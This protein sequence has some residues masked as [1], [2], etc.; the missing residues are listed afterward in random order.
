MS[1]SPK[2]PSEQQ[3]LNTQP[4]H[5]DMAWFYSFSACMVPFTSFYIA[6]TQG[7]STRA[8]EA[9][10]RSPIGVYG[11]LALPFVTL[12]MEKSIYDTVQSWQGL[13]PTVRPKDRGGFP[14][15]GAELL[16]SFSLIPVQKIERPSN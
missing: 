3:P 10:V 2:E 8:V 16:P 15:G 12:A 5:N 7:L 9:V 4:P 11:L 14:S 13:D 6:H 1:S